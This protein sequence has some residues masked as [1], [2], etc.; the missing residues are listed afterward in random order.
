MFWELARAMAR[1][2]AQDFLPHKLRRPV[3]Y[4]ALLFRQK[5]FDFVVI[6]RMHIVSHDRMRGS[7][8]VAQAELNG[9]AAVGK[10]FHLY[11]INAKHH[12]CADALRI[13]FSA[14]EGSCLHIASGST[15]AWRCG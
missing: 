15:A 8:A 6:E 13:S 5:F 7:L 2:D 9:D 12:G 14:F 4:G 11:V 10:S 3:A 1:R